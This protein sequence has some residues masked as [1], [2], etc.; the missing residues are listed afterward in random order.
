MFLT[1]DKSRVQVKTDTGI[2]RAYLTP[3]RGEITS[4]YMSGDAMITVQTTK[5]TFVY[6]RIGNNECS[7]KLHRL[8]ITN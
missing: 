3:T 7:W 8:Y 4:A 6:T 5:A 2:T 1:F